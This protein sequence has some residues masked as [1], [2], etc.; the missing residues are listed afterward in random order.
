MA[1]DNSDSGMKPTQQRQVCAGLSHKAWLIPTDKIQEI[2]PA[3]IVPI[4][5][6]EE[7]AKELDSARG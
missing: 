5:N 2:W 6:T 3:R 7:D 4:P 1:I